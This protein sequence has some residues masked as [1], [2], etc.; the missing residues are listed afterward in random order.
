[1]ILKWTAEVGVGFQLQHMQNRK[2]GRWIDLS[3]RNSCAEVPRCLY[4]RVFQIYQ[5]HLC[6]NI[7]SSLLLGQKQQQLK[8]G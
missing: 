5:W 1:M 3:G 8:L 7:N 4:A 2:H 6:R